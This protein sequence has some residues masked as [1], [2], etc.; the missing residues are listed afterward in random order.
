[1]VV[2]SATIV[3]Q[4]SDAAGLGHPQP[5]A[6]AFAVST[7]DDGG[8]VLPSMEGCGAALKEFVSVEGEDKRECWMMLEREE[9]G[10]HGSDLSEIR[11][12][13]RSFCSRLRWVNQGADRR[14]SQ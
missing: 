9:A 1:M 10:A 14:T 7:R 12:A 6:A 3:G 11:W 13:R 2:E 8:V 4:K 5:S